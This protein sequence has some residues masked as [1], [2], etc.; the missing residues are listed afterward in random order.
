M[1]GKASAIKGL[2]GLFLSFSMTNSKKQ[3]LCDFEIQQ[4]DPI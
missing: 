4:N 2:L 1:E 3:Y